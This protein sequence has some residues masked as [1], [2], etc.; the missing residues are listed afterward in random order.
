MHHFYNQNT[1]FNQ[2]HD[3]IPLSLFGNGASEASHG[4]LPAQ[5]FPPP[6]PFY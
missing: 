2:L 6:Q 3:C 4:R 5:K 1:L